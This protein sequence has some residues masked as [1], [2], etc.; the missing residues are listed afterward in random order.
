MNHMKNYT[1]IAVLAALALVLTVTPA[2]AQPKAALV[3]SADEP[4]R[5]PFKVNVSCSPTSSVNCQLSQPAIPAGKRFVVQYVSAF[6]ET[7]N[8][9]LIYMS[10]G[11][12]SGLV[13]AAPATNVGLSGPA[14]RLV[15]SQPVTGFI[16][17]GES[18]TIDFYVGIGGD[19]VAVVSGYLVDLTI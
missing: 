12:S 15:V 19:G 18:W 10:V 8:S 9:G 1:G 3:K 17:P 7:T 16:N 13:F 4:G 6:I 2:A 5:V 14:K 11:S